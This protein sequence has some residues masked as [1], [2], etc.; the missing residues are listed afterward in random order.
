VNLRGAVHALPN[1]EE[2]VELFEWLALAEQH[3]KLA[4]R[5]AEIVAIDFLDAPGRV[6]AEGRRN[7]CNSCCERCIRRI[8]EACPCTAVSSS[9]RAL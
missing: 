2:C 6:A 3:A 9:S 5:F 4:E 1:R 7:R 8:N